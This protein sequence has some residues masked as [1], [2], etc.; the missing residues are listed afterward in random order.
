MLTVSK[1]YRFR[2]F[3]A[4][5]VVVLAA[6][7]AALPILAATITQT[8]KAESQLAPGTVVSLDIEASTAIPGNASN[9]KNLFGVVVSSGDVEFQKS[10]DGNVLVTNT[11]VINT[12]VSTL[13]GPIA[14][15]DPITVSIVEGIGEKAV[16]SG[17][18]IGT[19]QGSFDGESTQKTFT[20]EDEGKPKT[21]KV[22]VI[23][24]KIE[25]GNFSLSNPNGDDRGRLQQIADDIANK[26]VTNV[27]LIVAGLILIVSTGIASF[28]IA[29]TG[30]ASMVAIGRNPLSEKKIIRSLLRLIGI[31]LVIFGVGVGLAYIILKVL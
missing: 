23:P 6:L 20:V 22:G 17:K 8:F 4:T 31:A 15:G 1:T 27:A 11:G 25:V 13:N 14:Q 21:V 19:A 12:L 29:S 7:F 10:S 28:M 3:I 5:S 2:F 24:V 26:R 18:I 30:Y 9:I 16:R